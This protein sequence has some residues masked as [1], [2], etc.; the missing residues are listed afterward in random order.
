MCD[1]LQ[2]T[3]REYNDKNVLRTYTEYAGY[4]LWQSEKVLAGKFFKATDAIL[5]IGCG[6]GRTTVGLHKMGFKNIIGLDLSVGMIAAAKGL[7]KLN[8]LD[9]E[10]VTGNA[11]DLPFPDNS[12]DKALFS[13]N[14]IMCIPKVK[15]RKKAFSEIYRVLKPGG[16]FIFTAH[17]NEDESSKKY[18]A[19]WAEE[20]AK[21]ER[22][23]QDKSLEIFGDLIANGGKEGSNFIHISTLT[24]AKEFIATQPFKL[25]Y[26]EMRRNIAAVP[27]YEAD[28]FGECRFFAVRKQ[29][30]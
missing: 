30:F 22:G 29:V 25:L 16:I 27:E 2:S 5:D 7:A 1:K 8:G 28:N 17:D 15:N 21:W 19:F 12:F 23:E 24:E 4:G 14:G 13:Y 6:A 10:F 9:I 20:K 18:V 26:T 3:V 11:L